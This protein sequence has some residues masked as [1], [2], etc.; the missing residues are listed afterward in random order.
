M[1]KIHAIVKHKGISELQIDDPIYHQFNIDPVT[2][3]F[4]MKKYRCFLLRKDQSIKLK[5]V[6]SFQLYLSERA[7]KILTGL[8]ESGIESFWDFAEGW[9][10]LQGD[11]ALQLNIVEGIEYS[12]QP[13]SISLESHIQIVFFLLLIGLSIGLVSFA[14]EVC[15]FIIFSWVAKLKNDKKKQSNRDIVLK[16]LGAL[17]YPI[18]RVASKTRTLEF[19]YLP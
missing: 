18:T 1:D 12:K 13:Q 2:R 6:T 11:R 14:G 9:R 7:D 17:N 3:Q 15:L 4:S 10:L 19:V 16:S 8:R 5:V